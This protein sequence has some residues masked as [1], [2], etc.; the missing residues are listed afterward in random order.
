M[1]LVQT[2]PSG[3]LDIVGDIHGE[4]AALLQLLRHLG[5]DARGN[6]PEGRTL[7]FLGDF[8]DRGPDSPGVIG[9][10]H[11]LVTS[12][13]AVAIAG[14]HEINLLRNDP[15]DGSGWFFDAR[16]Q[17]DLRKYQIGRAHV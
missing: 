4:Q 12:G 15:K 6:H 9:I 3:P 5:Y 11:Q 7:V 13:K 14:N 2:L 1:S 8:V 17:S 10:V 16:L